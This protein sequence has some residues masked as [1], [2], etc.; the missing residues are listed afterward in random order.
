MLAVVFVSFGVCFTDGVFT[1][2]W[3]TPFIVAVCLF[4]IITLIVGL[5]IYCKGKENRFIGAK[6]LVSLKITTRKV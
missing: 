4:V 2:P 6:D 1:R 3:K 5:V